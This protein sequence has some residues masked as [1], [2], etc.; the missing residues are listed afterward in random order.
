[1]SFDE[2]GLSSF[3]PM[4]IGFQLARKIKSET[5]FDCFSGVGGLAIAFAC[6]GK[7]VHGIDL[8][9]HRV[10]L[11]T[12]N[13]KLFNVEEQVD[14]ICADALTALR[15][16]LT[17]RAVVLDPPWGGT[18]YGELEYFK[19]NHFRPDGLQLLSVAFKTQAEILMLLPKNFDMRELE[20]FKRPQHIVENVLT[21]E[22]L[23]YAV[24]FPAL[25]L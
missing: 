14:F 25:D 22:L 8:S 20:Q 17:G 9:H 3:T 19:L 10:Q 6:A 5:V 2:E 21:G 13:A 24:I 4:P 12:A 15:N 23:S 16:D 11:A 7:R 18:A 1:M